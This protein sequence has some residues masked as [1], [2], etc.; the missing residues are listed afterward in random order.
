M[1]K[2]FEK[3]GLEFN[4]MHLEF[5]KIDA[6]FDQVDKRFEQVDQRLNQV[7]KRLDGIY[8]RFDQ[9]DARFDQ[10]DNDISLI[11]MT[12]SK[13]YEEMETEIK[14]INARM[15]TKDYLDRRLERFASVN[16]LVL[17]EQ[18]PDYKA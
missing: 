14:S 4:K 7:D 11:L 10:V 8:Q 12:V 6:R 3:I 1:K 9:V 2:E 15:V 5:R 17:R 16:H 13:T 18:G